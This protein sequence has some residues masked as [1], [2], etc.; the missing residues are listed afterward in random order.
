MSFGR[1]HAEAFLEQLAEI[2]LMHEAAAPG[3][4]AEVGV[5]FPRRRGPGPAKA[6]TAVVVPLA[7][8]TVPV[9]PTAQHPG[10]LEPQP[11]EIRNSGKCVT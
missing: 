9:Q 5:Q 3:A 6:T 8:V 11:I 7:V 4:R 10:G 1:Q 2:R